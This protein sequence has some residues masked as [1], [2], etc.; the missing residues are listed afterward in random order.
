MFDDITVSIS[1]LA[2]GKYKFFG[3]S[4]S[5]PPLAEHLNG[6]TVQMPKIE[7]PGKYEVV[8]EDALVGNLDPAFIVVRWIGEDYATILYHHGNTERP[9]DFRWYSPNT[10]RKIFLASKKPIQANLIALSAP[11]HRASIK[12]Y[13]KNLGNLSNFVALL[14]VSANMIEQLVSYL[15]E[16]TSKRV[17]VSGISLGGWIANIHRAYYNSADVYVPLLAGAALGDIFDTSIYRKMTGKIAQEHPEVLKNVLDFEDE[18]KRVK[19]DNVYPLLARYDQIIQYER[20]SACYGK[21]SI[22]TL[23]K[24]HISASIAYRDLRE[25]I[26]AHL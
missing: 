18:F 25:H 1:A 8:A 4:I 17:M 15:K 5:S 11:F 3:E 9:F 13:L 20:Q 26:L 2:L 19:D 10:F 12:H 14:A 24:G 7:G 16:R 21:R 22:K 23:A 6:T